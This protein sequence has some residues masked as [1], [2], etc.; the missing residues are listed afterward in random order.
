M[1]KTIIASTIGLLL[2]SGAIAAESSQYGLDEVVV[3]ASRTPQARENVIGD[4]SVIDRETIERAGQ[5]TLVELL[6]TQPGIEITNAGGPGKSSGIFIRGTNS[7]HVVVLVD[8][9]RLNSATAGTTTLENIPVSQIEKIEILRGPASSLYG[10]DAIGGVIQIFTKKGNGST[11]EP[12]LNAKMGYGSYGTKTADAGIRG[13]IANT[14]YALNVSSYDTDGFSAYRTSNP[15]LKDKDGYRNLS[16]TGSLSHEIAVGHTLGIQFFQS[17]GHVD[18]DNRFNTTAFGDNANINQFSYALTS[19][20]QFTKNWLSTLRIGEG[21]DKNENFAEVSIFNPISR[22]YFE[23]KQRQYSW[24][25]DI[26]L[27]AGT[28]TLMY[29]R[30]EQR[31]KSTTDYE[32]DGRNNDGFM[33]GYLINL[34]AHDFQINGRSDHNTA[35]GTN[36]TGNVGYGYKLNENWRVSGLYGTAFKAPSFNDLYYPP[37][38]GFPT[39]NPNLAPEKS[40]NIEATLNYKDASR[41]A[42]LTLYRNKIRDLI[43]LDAVTFIPYNV[44]NAD[45]KGLTLSGTQQLSS[46]NLKGSVDIQS[47]RDEDTDNLLVRRA[48]RHTSFGA[49]RE[50]GNWRFG[51]E[52]IG[53]G[54][55]YNDAANTQKLG[56]YTLV[57]LMADYKINQDWKLQ[58]RINNLFDKDYALAYDG[59]PNAGGFIYRTPGSNLFVSISYQPQ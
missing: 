18:Y 30:L 4:V 1:Q 25:N 6:Q 57:N 37:F 34:G 59:N 26:K 23:T 44:N 20:N 39:S 51:S 56:G 5:S 15:L 33:A 50:W 46:W 36:N 38:F 54:T 12:I 24:Q 10:A 58:G 52:V 16:F 28:L 45:I 21:S 11:G 31:V 27:P 53:S 7:S 55:R 9:I 35:Y 32:K 2:S 43:A 48:N 13:S 49:S 40:R 47:P 29:D 42:S 3:I 14:S 41:N 8:G 17:E 19:S 22:S